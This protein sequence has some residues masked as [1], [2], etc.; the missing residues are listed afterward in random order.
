QSDH[1]ARHHEEVPR[2]GIALEEAMLEDHPRVQ[3]AD[4]ARHLADIVAGGA[5]TIDVGHLDAIEVFE[6][7]ELPGAV[8]AIDVRYAHRRVVRHGGSGP[9]GAVRLA[10]EVELERYELGDLIDDGAQIEPPHHT[11][12]HPPPHAHPHH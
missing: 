3:A 9:L 5:Q 7:E 2:V 1:R 10:R 4:T 11:P 6:D 12:P 8:I